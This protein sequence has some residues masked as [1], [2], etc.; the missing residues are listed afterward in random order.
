VIE[1]PG[2]SFRKP[3]AAGEA[4]SINDR[5]D[6]WVEEELR[7]LDPGAQ[8]ILAALAV[9]G[10]GS[11]SVDQLIE[12]TG[13]SELPLTLAELER[14]SLVVRDGD[15]YALAPPARGPVKR[16]LA[17]VD[18]VDRV[19]RGFI[20]IAEDGRLTLDDLDAIV[21]LTGIA[22]E[23]QRWRELIRLAEA[24]E[25]TLSTKHRVEE[26]IEIAERRGE[27]RRALDDE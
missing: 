18:I 14:R 20:R 4:R 15:R 2:Q 23:T 10:R 25:T 12:I 26:W 7:S 24:A 13:L 6:A 21:E 3:E 16:L 19:L 27:A 9:C 1:H 8:D 22:A 11:L 5:D 17:S